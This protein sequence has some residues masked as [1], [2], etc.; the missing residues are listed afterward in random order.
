MSFG[1]IEALATCLSDVVLICD[2]QDRL[3]WAN[4]AAE[5]LGYGADELRS[6]EL[7]QVLA[8]LGHP[9]GEDD[10]PLSSLMLEQVETCGGPMSAKLRHR[11]GVELEVALRVIQAPESPRVIFIAQ[12]LEE[13]LGRARVATPRS[14]DLRIS[15]EEQHYELVFET[16]PIGLLHFDAS[17]VITAVND[18]FAR[19]VASTR[20]LLIGLDMKS[21]PNPPIVAAVEQAIAGQPAVFQGEYHSIIAQKTV[22]A[23]VQFTPVFDACGA[24]T[25]GVGIVEDVTERLETQRALARAERMASLG[26]LAAGVAHEIN[27]PLAFTITGLDLARR[28]ADELDAQDQQ[29]LVS[30]IRDTLRDAHEGGERVRM[31]VRDLRTFARSADERR[32]PVD[33]EDVLDVAAKL[34]S[35]ELRHRARLHR[36]YSGVPPVWGNESRLV[37]VFVN[38]LVNAARAIEEGNVEGNS[39][40]IVT[41]YD[42]GSE[43]ALIE[44]QDTGAGIPPQDLDRIFEPFWTK[45]SGTGLGLSICHGII[46]AHDGEI[47][48]ESQPGEGSLFRVSLPV[49]PEETPVDR[50]A[51]I[52]HVAP[53]VV[54]RRLRVLVIDDEEALCRTL[55]LG[56][57]GAHDVELETSGR[58]GLERLRSSPTF[59]VVLCDLMLPDLPAPDLFEAVTQ[60]HPEMAPRFIFMTGG[61]FTDRSR[62][63]L[64]RVDNP[65]LEKPFLLAELETLLAERSIS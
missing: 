54:D 63:F 64:Q 56:L 52:T 6:L 10:R 2:E 42:P 21:L 51:R 26:T 1:D 58:G 32:G 12:L 17:G 46:S 60:S 55:E 36:D 53:P 45:G 4:P 28:L 19:I 35:T 37:Q 38:L 9:D 18:Q 24:V 8:P 43:Q 23:Q 61:A 11:R 3:L 7:K 33:I 49:S 22:Q 44:I 40:Q 16:A 50:D 20:R 34:T 59:D 65:R 41:R 62:A 48:A 31:L 29:Q 27:N 30:Q 14:G 39:V 25:G 57:A 13:A 5:S 47:I 15:A